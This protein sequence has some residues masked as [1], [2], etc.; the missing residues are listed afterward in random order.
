MIAT[1]IPVRTAAGQAELN[2]RE[3]RI[4]Q[5]HR[6]VLFLIDGKRSAAEVRA[7]A[8][9]AGVPGSCFDELI[10]SGL[11][12]AS[13]AGSVD[14]ARPPAGAATA[15]AGP[16]APAADPLD[17]APESELP[18]SLSLS[19]ESGS[20]DSIVGA[21]PVT[22]WQPHEDAAAAEAADPAFAEAREILLRAVR[23]EAPIAGALT[24]RRLRRARHRDDLLALLDEVEARIS[25]PRRVL[26]TQQT[27]R[28]VR[29]LLGASVSSMFH[30]A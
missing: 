17:A 14:A 26:T 21:Q 4:S 19:P 3:R 29:H 8:V 24:L 22:D 18:A 25:K 13:S 12:A 2:T 20:A 9:Q 23:S 6:T 1:T 11:I 10:A 28:R 15:A 30:F 5:R 16:S 7:M 27:M